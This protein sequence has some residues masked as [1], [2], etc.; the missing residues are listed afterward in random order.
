MPVIVVI[1]PWSRTWLHCQISMPPAVRTP[2][3]AIAK[4]GQRRAPAVGAAAP[5][6]HDQRRA[7]PPSAR[8]GAIASQ[9]TRRRRDGLDGA[10]N[11]FPPSPSSAPVGLALDLSIFWISSD[12]RRLGLAVVA[13][14]LEVVH[15]ALD[16]RLDA[17][18]HRL[19]VEAEEQAAAP[20]SGT[21]T[22]QLA[23][24]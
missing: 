1:G 8:L 14:A 3:T 9:S 4:R 17:V 5:A 22:T 10:A 11:H 24:A 15:R 20:S 21:T 12:R 7:A 23:E 16:R 2:T 19:R 18:E 13:L 6:Q